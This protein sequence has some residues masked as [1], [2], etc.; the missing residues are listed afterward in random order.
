MNYKYK[1]KYSQL[2]NK[3]GG[4]NIIF[5]QE[6]GDTIRET[7]KEIFPTAII[8]I[9]N[10]H[11]RVKIKCI[12]T[13]KSYINTIGDIIDFDIIYNEYIYINFLLKCNQ[14]SG[15]KNL[16]KIVELGKILKNITN[17]KKISLID[18]STIIL[19]KCDFSLSNLHILIYGISWYNKYGF[20]SVTYENELDNNIKLCEL[21]LI[22]FLEKSSNNQYNSKKTK[23]LNEIKLMKESINLLNSNI[24]LLRHVQKR[25][26][27]ILKKKYLNIKN[28]LENYQES[29]IIKFKK[30]KDDFLQECSDLFNNIITNISNPSNIKELSFDS[31]IS[32]IIEKIY[33][34]SKI[35]N[36]DCNSDEIKF[37][38]KIMYISDYII[39]YDNKLHYEL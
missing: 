21:D 15:H 10:I 37:L 4:G 20:L 27:S 16:E 36:L 12:D 3:I 19:N 23:M 17:I 7:I 11:T 32:L 2:K 34:Y 1:N 30:E 26:I 5:T 33:N 22:Y 35:N 9:N 29:E 31:K 8:D 14:L 38:I 28:N 6:M 39:I 24:E 25:R 13:P 18:G